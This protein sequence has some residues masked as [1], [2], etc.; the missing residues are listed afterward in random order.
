MKLAGLFGLLAFCFLGYVQLAAAQIYIGPDWKQ[1][2]VGPMMKILPL[3]AKPNCTDKNVFSGKCDPLFQNFD[4]SFVKGQ[5]SA[6]WLTLQITNQTKKPKVLY[7]GSSRFEYMQC[8]IKTS[9]ALTGPQLSGQN[10][11]EHQKTVPI[12]GY[13]FFSFTALPDQPITIYIKAINKNA[14]LTPQFN[15]SFTL[16]DEAT[17]KDVFEK[18]AGYTFIFMGVIICM[19]V[20]NCILFFTTKL[21]VYLYYLGY[22]TSATIFSLGLVPQLSYPLFGH[23]DVN[24]QPIAFVGSLS[25][26]FYILVAQEVM[27]VKKFFPRLSKIL[28]VVVI[29]QSISSSLIVVPNTDLLRSIINYPVTMTAFPIILFIGFVMSIRRHQPSILF[30]IASSI[31]LT[32]TLVLI[33]QLLQVLP[34]ELLN[35]EAPTLFQFDLSWEATLTSLSLGARINEMRRRLTQEQIAKGKLEQEHEHERRQLIELQ[36]SLLEKQVTERTNELRQSLETLKATQEQLIQREKMAFLGELTAGIA[37]EIQNPLNFVNNFAEVSI[38][39]IQEL[40]TEVQAGQANEIII[41]ADYL[42][43]NLIKIMHHGH[44]AESIVKGMLM[45]SRTNS[46]SIQPVQINALVE[47]FLR[48]AYHGFRSND[49]GDSPGRF[50][51]ELT[52]NFDETIGIVNCDPQQL[53]QVLLNLYTNAF[54]AVY[55]KQKASPKTYRPEV[56]V[57]TQNTADRILIIIHDN[58]HGIAPDTMKKIFQPFFTT[59]PAGQGTGLGLSLSYDM[60]VKGLGG[61]LTVQSEEGEFAEFTIRLPKTP[62]ETE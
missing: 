49:K 54:Y 5:R 59:K 4:P 34:Y 43:S 25:I 12:V 47:E 32:G 2:V 36:N 7:L 55:Q 3:A 6:N 39:L 44:Q 21:R 10:V 48:L 35:L 15:T 23:A 13:S 29:A 18:P 27:E 24:R 31:Y 14:P 57:T 30:F 16:A 45:H 19:L 51:T 26:L 17:F 1:Q 46:G 11:P 52:T 58:G 28:T 62:L 33:L 20:Y 61:E 41:V 42:E 22:V 56:K 50:N 60:T 53:S 37:H 9:T 40:K 38:E 8:W